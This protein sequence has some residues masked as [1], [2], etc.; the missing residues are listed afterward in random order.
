MSATKENIPGGESSAANLTTAGIAAGN[1][2]ATAPGADIMAGNTLAFIPGT[3]IA[4]ANTRD[5]VPGTGIAAGTTRAFVPGVGIT[6]GISAGRTPSITA[7]IT[8]RETADVNQGATTST[9]ASIPTGIPTKPS[10]QDGFRTLLKPPRPWGVHHHHAS[11]PMPAAS[12]A[13]AALASGHIQRG[14]G[15]NASVGM[16][17]MPSNMIFGIGAGIEMPA[18]MTFGNGGGAED[19]RGF[20]PPSNPTLA[21]LLSQECQKRHFNPVFQSWVSQDNRQKCSVS[22][23]GRVIYDPSGYDDP[24]EAKE[25]IAR[26]ALDAVLKMPLPQATDKSK[27]AREGSEKAKS[28]VKDRSQA[29]AR[30][31]SEHREIKSESRSG[32]HSTPANNSRRR[33]SRR[34]D[35]RRRRNNSRAAPDGRRHNDNSRAAPDR[36]IP[37]YHNGPGPVVP[38]N[39]DQ[40]RAVSSSSHDEYRTLMNRLQSLVGDRTGPSQQI[41]NDPLAS[42]A[43]LWGMVTGSRVTELVRRSAESVQQESRGRPQDGGGSYLKSLDRREQSPAPSPARGRRERSPLA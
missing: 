42:Q 29:S 19:A 18:N 21:T 31:K 11:T 1:T 34:H 23:N 6:S 38:Q 17:G 41:L 35:G 15:P 28:G 14:F 40:Y 12:A 5:F 10:G 39:A 30:G 33:D 3:G 43:Y 7:G 9:N 36:Y 4:T 2:R 16:I 27:A 20:Q 22:L 24:V 13:P 37:D 26:Q 32:R 25:N 8:P